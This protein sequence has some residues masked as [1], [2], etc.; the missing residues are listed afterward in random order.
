VTH[1][2]VIRG[3]TV[4]DGSGAPPVRADVAIDDG[5]VTAVGTVEDAGREELDAGNCLVTPGFVDPHTHLDAQLCWDPAATPTCLHGVT[6]VVLGICGFGIAPCPPGGGDYLLRSLEV[7][8]EI[9]F[10]SSSLGVP[11]RG[12][13][14]RSSSTTSAASRWA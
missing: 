12:S 2:L 8:E 7:V 3:G 4:V 10:A 11:S 5:T 14:G 1:D 6:T 9:P 13:R